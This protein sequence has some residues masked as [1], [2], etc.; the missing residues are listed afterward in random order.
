MRKNIKG[1][2]QFEQ[3]P[4]YSSNRCHRHD[5]WTKELGRTRSDSSNE[6]EKQKPTLLKGTW[7]KEEH[8][9]PPSNIINIL[10]SQ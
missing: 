4:R 2:A 5:G 9:R 7:P 1:E 6:T 3:H 8:P 10:T